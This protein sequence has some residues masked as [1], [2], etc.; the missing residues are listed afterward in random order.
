VSQEGGTH[1]IFHSFV[2]VAE[3][4]YRTIIWIC[5]EKPDYDGRDPIFVHSVPPLA[6]AILDQVFTVC[7][8]SEDIEERSFR[9]FKAGWREIAEKDIRERQRY[10][11]DKKWEE[12]LSTNV[13]LLDK[14]GEL[15]KVTEAERTTLSLIKKFPNPGRMHEECNI[16]SLKDYLI[17]LNDWFYKQ[18]S[19]EAHLSATGLITRAFPQVL[20]HSG[21]IP[22]QKLQER[23]G[24]VRS[25]TIV[26]TLTLTVALLSEIQAILKFPSIN[27]ELCYLWTLLGGYW[28]DPDDL[29]K[30]RY[31]SLLIPEKALPP[32]R[33][34]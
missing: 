3:T 19:Q 30:R 22:E 16:S 21:L 11:Y 10:S 18:L 7:F 12:V 25:S 13:Q 33:F 34:A 5:A 4:T 27:Q 9:Y 8:L 15:A 31:Q 14:L 17:F 2:V 28:K 1:I 6:R 20:V 26:T 29:Y 24:Q 23:L 32:D